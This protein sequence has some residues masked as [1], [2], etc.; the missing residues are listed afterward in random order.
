MWSKILRPFSNKHCHLYSSLVAFS[1]LGYSSREA[2]FF[3]RSPFFVSTF[4]K[5]SVSSVNEAYV[6]V[7]K[8]PSLILLAPYLFSLE[9][10]SVSKMFLLRLLKVQTC[11]CLCRGAMFLNLLPQPRPHNKWLPWS[12]RREELGRKK[13][14][15][16]KRKKLRRKLQFISNKGYKYFH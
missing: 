1:R 14:P 3:K 16:I 4:S 15:K 8:C 5:V 9:L 11:S 12:L 7:V 6:S 13:G 10:A 2:H